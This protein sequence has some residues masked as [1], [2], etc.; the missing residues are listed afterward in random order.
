CIAYSYKP[1]YG[2]LAREQGLSE[3]TKNNIVRYCSERKD[4][5]LV[6]YR[7]LLDEYNISIRSE[8]VSLLNKQLIENEKIFEDSEKTLKFYGS[9]N[10]KIEENK[11]SDKYAED[12][13]VRYSLTNTLKGEEKILW[14]YSDTSNK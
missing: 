10:R 1:D 2:K 5:K 3:E 11:E 13:V 14:G 9:N 7:N 8:L 6:E 4:K 12:S